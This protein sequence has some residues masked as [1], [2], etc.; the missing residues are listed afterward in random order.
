MLKK[1]NSPFV[2]SD[3]FKRY[4]T[5]DY[6]LKH[7]YNKKMCKIVLSSGMTCPNRDGTRGLGGCSFCSGAGGGEFAP[8][9][10]LSL[11]EQ[12]ARG[13]AVM[14]AKWRD[15][16]FI[17]Y[18]QAFSN[19]HAPLAE[20]EQMLSQA[21]ELPQISA[22]RIATRADCVDEHVVAL[23]K[24]SNELLPVSVE[25]GLQTIHD[26]TAVRIN[27][28]HS[29]GEFCEGYS[30]VKNAGLAVCVHLING[31]PGESRA[32]MLQTAKTVGRLRP[33]GVKLHMLHLLHGT[34]LYRQY[35][36]AP[37]PL[38][39][40]EEYIG[41]VCEQLLYFPP[42]TVIERLTGDGDANTLAAPAWTR[43]KLQIINDIDKRLYHRD[44]FQGMLFD[45]KG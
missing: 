18:F 43:N 30:R 16:G 17:G 5:L 40:N 25:L 19:T 28:C 8:D 11:E 12:Y 2:Y 44:E 15:A 24:R 23:L 1:H 26:K 9:S 21:A 35:T 34:E 38:L 41:L 33:D 36:Q 20:L 42:E 7:I 31:L 6:H 4:Y 45:E 3:G 32:Q 14:Q 27:R 13:I 10:R 37:F 22:L 29:F 39:T